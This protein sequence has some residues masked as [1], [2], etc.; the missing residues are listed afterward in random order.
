MLDSKG[1]VTLLNKEDKTVADVVATQIQPIAN[2]V[3]KIVESFKNGGRLIY[4]GAG[5]SGRLGILD[6]SEM[7]PTYNTDPSMVVG[8]IAGGTNAIQNPVEGAEDDMEQAAV[9]LK[10]I[11]LSSKDTLVGIS[12]SGRTPYVVAG[13]R[14]ANEIGA[15]SV[16]VATSSDSEIGKVASIKIEAVTG[17]EPVTGS[18]RMKSGT[19]QKL[20]LNSLSTASMIRMGKI[21]QN[22][23]VDVVAL[24]AKLVERTKK[25]VSEITNVSFDEAD[26][27]LSQ[28]ATNQK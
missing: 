3:D 11:N 24:N 8:L 19:A 4:I 2:A 5:T 10:E 16:S 13:L 23:M 7:P 22:L 6:A 21:Y 15:T 20:I 27:A 14:Y 26:K 17:P 9:D 12:A 18:T 28:Y 25:I 1:I